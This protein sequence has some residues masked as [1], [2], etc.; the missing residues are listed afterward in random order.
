MT[1][2]IIRF[3]VMSI[4]FTAMLFIVFWLFGKLSHKP[5]DLIHELKVSA[6]IG[7]LSSFLIVFFTR[8]FKQT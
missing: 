2:K 3:L 1:K 7:I 6:L 4:A 8:F 5:V